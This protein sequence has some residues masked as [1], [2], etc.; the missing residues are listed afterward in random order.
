MQSNLARSR[1]L[2]LAQTALSS[3]RSSPPKG[4]SVPPIQLQPSSTPHIHAVDLAHRFLS[5]KPPSPNTSIAESPKEPIPLPLNLNGLCSDVQHAPL[6]PLRHG[7]SSADFADQ[8]LT[9]NVMLRAAEVNT[10]GI[11]FDRALVAFADDVVC[12][13]NRLEAEAAH[14]VCTDLDG[15]VRD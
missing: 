8:V 10:L 12:D 5:L 4:S 7:L 6:A 11:D 9:R 2:P 3:V 14:L 15:D 13:G 1:Y